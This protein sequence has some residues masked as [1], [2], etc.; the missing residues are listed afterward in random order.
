MRLLSKQIEQV[1][2]QVG[3]D[4]L[5]FPV[6]HVHVFERFTTEIGNKPNSFGMKAKQ[7]IAKVYEFITNRTV[8]QH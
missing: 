1:S 4:V 7:G 3:V 6:Y 8:K 5:G 2:F